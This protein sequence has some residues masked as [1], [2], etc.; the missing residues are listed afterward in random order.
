MCSQSV[1]SF[2]A[3]EDSKL[4]LERAGLGPVLWQVESDAYARRVL[5]KHWPSVARYEDARSVGARCLSP[6]DLIC[7]GFPCQDLSYAGKGAG[8]DGARSGLWSEFARLIRELRPRYVVVENVPALLSRGMGRVLGDLA[9]S[10]YD[11]EW[12]CIPAQAV[13]APHRR[14]RVFLVAYAPGIGCDGERASG[15]AVQVTVRGRDSRCCADVADADD[16]GEP[17][18][19]VNDGARDCLSESPQR[20]EWWESEPDVGRVAHGVPSR[21]DRLRC[22]GNAVVP[23]VAEHIGRMIIASQK[24]SSRC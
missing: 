20:D 5:A 4:G 12:D 24:C 9:A 8:I 22:L 17:G 6:V 7:G 11:A 19:A 14:D 15:S 10:G 3:S 21:L 16:Q 1:P 13:G 2:Q 23:Q 18:R